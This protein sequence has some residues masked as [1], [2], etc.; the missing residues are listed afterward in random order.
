MKRVQ[1]NGFFMDK[2]KRIIQILAIAVLLVIT[3]G[4][5]SFAYGQEN[6]KEEKS[7]ANKEVSVDKLSE[8]GG[9]PLK[10]EK[11]VDMESQDKEN[12]ETTVDSSKNKEEESKVGV[13]VYEE[14]V[15]RKNIEKTEMSPQTM[16]AMSLYPQ[17]GKVNAT[18]GLNL[19]SGP[20][21]EYRV[22]TGI[23][24]GSKITILDKT[25]S[26]YKVSYAGYTGYVSSQYV[27]IINTS[28]NSSEDFEK[29]LSNQGFSESYKVA[30][31][32]IHA[33]YPTWVFRADNTGLDW[34]YVLDKE[35]RYGINTINYGDGNGWVPAPKSK[36]E[37]YLNTKNFLDEVSIFQFINN[38]YEQGLHT[39][40]GVEKII[41]GTFMDCAFPEY[42]YSTYVDVIMEA[43]R[44]SGVSPY[45]LASMI[46][47][48]QGRYGSPSAKGISVD[49]CIYYNFYNIGATDGGDPNWKGAVYAKSQGWNTRAKAIIGGA[50]WFGDGYVNSGQYTPY[51]KK[52]NVMNGAYAVATHQY[53]S[54]IS[55]AWQEGTTQYNGYRNAFGTGL[56]FNI[57]IF[58]NMPSE[59]I[60]WKSESG[61]YV[62]IDKNGNKLKG[63]Q[64]IDG[65]IYYFD[66][67]TGYCQRGIVE[68]YG[69][70]YYYDWNDYNLYRDGWLYFGGYNLKNVYADKTTGAFLTGKQTINGRTSIFDNNGYH[71]YGAFVQNGKEYFLNED[72]TKAKGLVS[73]NGRNYYYY[74]DD[75]TLVK[76]RWITL[77]GRDAYADEKDGHF[78]I[79]MKNIKGKVYLFG[80]DGFMITTP[81]KHTVA[82]KTY[83]VG[84][85]SELCRGIVEEN[86][87]RYYFDW[88]DYSLYNQGWLYFSGYNKQ[89]VYTD[90]ITGEFLTGQQKITDGGSMDGEYFFN[91]DGF[92]FRGIKEFNGKRYYYDWNNYKLVKQ[93]WLYFSGY[94]KQWVYTDKTTGEFLTGKCE[95][96]KYTYFFDENGYCQRGIVEYN[97]GNYYYDWNTYN[98]YK[99]GWLY[100]GGYNQ[101]WVY[102]STVNGKFLTGKW[103]INGKTC[104]FDNEGF[105]ISEK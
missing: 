35:S 49:G 54:N 12:G 100:F 78:C 55:G 26:W 105:L 79:G 62:Y 48:E 70:R 85:D 80:N 47:N 33:K 84:K 71:V 57:P 60:G 61:N 7:K 67:T 20:S 30:L 103:I 68:E 90:K 38:K 28:N 24:N 11:N 13:P 8:N 18:G 87:K 98:L 23:P 89:W 65:E 59:D 42:G 43:A 52:F 64:S 46:I 9:D 69:K 51:L 95:F 86:G 92:R 102:A 41:R 34:S 37:Y 29:Y 2:T 27:D 76:D 99:K 6:S 22:K 94:N 50:K 21:K 45:M 3:I 101:K 44:Q 83:Y 4:C 16:R 72:G 10:K 15:E 81:G 104:I 36:V 19:R 56:I 93:G 96:G 66:K 75:C 14:N 1:V 17:Y 88:N 77:H 31:R 39:R 40:E 32:E 63:R 82:G 74:Q 97:D 58:R 5:M 25:G 73:D 91:D 53:M